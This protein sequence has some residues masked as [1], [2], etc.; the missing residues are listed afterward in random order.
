[1]VDYLVQTPDNST[2]KN[3]LVSL[4]QTAL[5]SDQNVPTRQF[6]TTMMP[7]LSIHASSRIFLDFHIVRIPQRLVFPTICVYHNSAIVFL[8]AET[9]RS[10][11]SVLTQTLVT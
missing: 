10:Q 5:T 3:N 11:V 1:M 7:A 9:N 8:D 2:P 4:P 6:V